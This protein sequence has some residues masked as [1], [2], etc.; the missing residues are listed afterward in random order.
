[1]YFNRN[2][3]PPRRAT[4]RPTDDRPTT[5]RRPTASSKRASLDDD[6]DDAA[7]AKR[8]MADTLKKIQDFLKK[9]HD[10]ALVK[11]K[12]PI[13]IVAMVLNIVFPGVGTLVACVTVNK[14]FEGLKCFAMMW[15]MC[16]VLFVGWVWS[17][18]HGVQ[19]F[20]KASA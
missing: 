16:F 11:A 1:M 5:D 7:R 13:A 20:M 8:E 18:V 14:T 10:D 9:T 2:Q 19:L 4:G 3:S 6:D 15:L 12:K 17:I